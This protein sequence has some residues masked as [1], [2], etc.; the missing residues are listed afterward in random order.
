MPGNLQ[1]YQRAADN[2]QDQS[3]QQAENQKNQVADQ[4][5]QV[6]VD[7]PGDCNVNPEMSLTLSGTGTAFDMTYFIQQVQH[8]ISWEGGYRMLVEARNKPGGS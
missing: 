3:Q 1:F 5:M 8:T 6:E 4:I 2:T 7:C